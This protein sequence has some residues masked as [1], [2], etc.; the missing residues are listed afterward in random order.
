MAKARTKVVK[1]GRRAVSHGTIPR[2][3]VDLDRRR[4]EEFP[5]LEFDGSEPAAVV[6]AAR[7]AIAAELKVRPD[8]VEVDVAVG[9]SSSATSDT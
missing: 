3:R 1:A 4:V 7:R 5:W 2:Y 6:E 8:Q 9:A